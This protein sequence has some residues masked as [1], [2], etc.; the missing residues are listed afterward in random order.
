MAHVR[1]D[2][3]VIIIEK[4]S[5]GFGGFLL[6][7]LVGAGAAL[8]LAPQSGEETREAL[9]ERGRKLRD[10][11]QERAEELGHR[12]EEGYGKARGHVEET[13]KTARRTFE[14]KRVGARDAVK[15]GRAAVHSARD[16]LERRL[17]D[18]RAAKVN[19][20]DVDEEESH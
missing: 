17:A 19:V 8:L 7:L 2:K 5:G 14:E 20:A 13:L 6:G 15:A 16:E 3:P 9:R 11:A 12:V 1:D 4:S 10:D 18:T